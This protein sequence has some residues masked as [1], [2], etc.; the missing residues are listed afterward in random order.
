MMT[1]DFDVRAALDQAWGNPGADDEKEITGLQVASVAT[2]AQPPNAEVQTEDQ[3]EA[4][5]DGDKNWKDARSHIDGLEADLKGYN[6]IAAP[7]GGL[8]GLQAVAPLVQ[9]VFETDPEKRAVAVLD[10]L[11]AVLPDETYKAIG[12]K[13]ATDNQDALWQ[14]IDANQD[15]LLNHFVEQHGDALRAKLGVQAV[16][17]DDDF[18][19]DDVQTAQPNAEVEALRAQL[20]EREQQLN[21]LRNRDTQQQ[22]QV[23]QQALLQTVETDAFSSVVDS[24]FSQAELADWDEAAQLQA[25]QLAQTFYRQDEKAVAAFRSALTFH[26][27]PGYGVF[28]GNAREAFSNYLA[29]AITAVG[30]IRNAKASPAANTPTPRTEILTAQPALNTAAMGKSGDPFDNLQ[31]R[32]MQRLSQRA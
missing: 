15:A 7:I 17:E 19:D 6:D 9:G 12:G 11:K 16:T 30:A 26:G 23:E 25:L 18:E 20:V 2:N 32:V 10:G 29:Q 5:P 3:P 24:A 4:K 31:E 28:A 13:L 22:T 27:K 1:E 14:L 8:Q 21:A